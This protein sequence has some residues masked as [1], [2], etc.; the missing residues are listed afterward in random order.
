M[1]GA[2][3]R[4]A[5]PATLKAVLHA[6][7]HPTRSVVGLLLAEE[8]TATGWSAARPVLVA[9]AVPLF[10]TAPSSV[11]T[12]AAL[13]LVR[14]ERR[15]GGGERAGRS[16]GGVEFGRRLQVDA[17]ARVQSPALCIVGVYYAESAGEPVEAHAL[18]I[19]RAATGRSAASERTVGAA[20]G[21]SGILPCVVAQVSETMG[22]EDEP[23]LAVRTILP[24]GLQPRAASTVEGVDSSAVRE[25]LRTYAT[26]R[27]SSSSDAAAAAAISLPVLL[28]DLDDFFE[29]PAADW[30]NRHLHS[31][32]SK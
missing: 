4:I 11:T 1:S 25:A 9:D 21:G 13:K 31:L 30:T 2:T 7:A 26:G 24:S 27:A 8:A 15:R 12:G 29:S 5:P 22:T 28:H 14:A 16:W 17:W 6:A 18:A 19:A 3:V 32:I 23:P 10:H 20:A